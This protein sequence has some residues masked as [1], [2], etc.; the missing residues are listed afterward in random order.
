MSAEEATGDYRRADGIFKFVL[1]KVSCRVLHGLY[2]DDVCIVMAC[3]VTACIVMACVVMEYIIMA[4]IVAA[5]IVTARTV[6]ACTVMACIVIMGPRKGQN[7]FSGRSL[8]DLALWSW[9]SR[10]YGEV[11]SRSEAR[12]EA[13][14][15]ARAAG[16][17]TAVWP[18]SPIGT[19]SRRTLA[20]L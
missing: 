6:M 10:S 8:R 1:N 9:A 11:V 20:R 14:T 3:I 2:S 19:S 4:C 7:F 15:A 12:R 18:P 16:V 5:Y 13:G 17:F